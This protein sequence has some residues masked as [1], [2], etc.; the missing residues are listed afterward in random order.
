[1]FVT[2]NIN[3]LAK[4]VNTEITCISPWGFNLAMGCKCKKNRDDEQ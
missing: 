1:M 4:I 2:I 3:I